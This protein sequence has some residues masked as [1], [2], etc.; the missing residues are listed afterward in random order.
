MEGFLSYSKSDFQKVK[1]PKITIVISVFNGEGFLK[2]VLRSIQ[3]QNFLDIE[4]IIVDD[5]SLDNSVK[6]IKELMEDDPR[7]ILLLNDV[8]RG[9]LYTKSKGVLNAKGKYVMTLD[10]D[11][12]YATKDAFYKLYQEAERNNLELLGFA[13]IYTTINIID[14]KEDSFHNYIKTPIIKKPFIKDRFLTIKL[15]EKPSSTLLYLYFIKTDLYLNILKILGDNFIHRNIDAGDDTIVIFLLSRYAQN[16]KHLKKIFHVILV[17]PNQNSPKFTIHNTVK[18]DER[19]KRNCFSYITYTEALL[20]FSENNLD[21]K[22]FAE[23]SFLTWFLRSEKCNKKI[24]IKNDIIRV[25]NLYLNNEYI[26]S[27]TKKEIL[28]YLNRT[29]QN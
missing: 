4:I 6:I 12:F 16:L 17:W 29:F 27:D 10:Q 15:I 19:E 22:K 2:P 26:S 14:L 23:I 3:N 20:L 24:N 8:N 7:I 5:A 13:S 21:D 1:I 9:T 28:F 25:C 11:N 18:Y